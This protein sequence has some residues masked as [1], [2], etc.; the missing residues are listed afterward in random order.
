MSL[1]ITPKIILRHIY[2]LLIC[3][4]IGGFFSALYM[5]F[6]I[7]DNINSF[8][9]SSLYGMLIGGGIWKGNQLLGYFMAIKYGWRDQ[10]T[11]T[12]VWD[13]ITSVVFSFIWINLC[14]YI[15][16]KY[17]LGLKGNWLVNQMITTGVITF[18]VTL[19]ITSFFYSKAFFKAWKETL[20]REAKY[21]AE[22]ERFHHQML[23]NQV[24]PHF[25]FNSLNT[26]TSLVEHNPTEAVKFIKKLSDVYRYVLEQ[27]NNEMVT[28]QEELDL[29]NS[30]IFM[31]QHR[32]GENFAVT[33]NIE[34][35]SWMIPPM[36][37][38]MLLENAI[39]HNTI[40]E[41]NPLSITIEEKGGYLVVSNS[42]KPRRS[43]GDET[44]IGLSN[45]KSRYEFLSSKPVLYG[46]ENGLHFVVRIPLIEPNS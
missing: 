33:I 4:A 41:E 46:P 29:V 17:A 43:V 6:H 36:S 2:D 34:H 5:K 3:A 44:G 38:Q 26:L 20:I 22:S 7:W 19:I 24:N 31:Q 25:L 1:Q 45:I 32:Y 14:D 28:L 9:I 42:L 11:K 13:I 23:K 16:F 40:T 15:F 27:R 30:Y 12:F 18:L 21:K 8:L 39:K 35:P 37:L 10:P